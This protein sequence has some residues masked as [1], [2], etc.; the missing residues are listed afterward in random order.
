MLQGQFSVDE[1]LARVRDWVVPFLDDAV[2]AVGFLASGVKVMHTVRTVET[3]NVQMED[4]KTLTDLGL[5]K[6]ASLNMIHR[7]SEFRGTEAM[8]KLFTSGDTYIGLAVQSPK[9]ELL[10]G[11]GSTLSS[12]GAVKRI[13]LDN[14]EL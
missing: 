13:E 8:T 2:V 14:R 7:K 10:G 12:V 3:G 6:G 9:K 11:G 5:E 1:P 4:A